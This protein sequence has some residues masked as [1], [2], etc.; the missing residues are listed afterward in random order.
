[1]IGLLTIILSLS[2]LFQFIATVLAMRLIRVTKHT[3]AWLMIASAIAIMTLRRIEPLVLLLSGDRANPPGLFYETAGLALS[4]LMVAGI[5]LIKPL[6]V[7][8]QHSEDALRDANAKLSLISQEQLILIAELQEALANNKTLKGML[9][10]CASCKN[11]RDDRGYWNQI[12][13]YVAEHSDA[14]FTHGICPDCIKKLY[15]EYC[16]IKD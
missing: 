3:T 5:Y 9:P 12:E 2:I 4:G 13:A 8:I 15:P 11:I 1:M 7:S 14:E 6:F 16:Q 10:I